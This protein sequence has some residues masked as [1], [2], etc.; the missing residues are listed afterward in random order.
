MKTQAQMLLKDMALEKYN[1]LC[2]HARLLVDYCFTNRVFFNG[3]GECGSPWIE[4]TICDTIEENLEVLLEPY[5][6]G[7]KIG[8]LKE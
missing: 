7:V 5:H 8:E 6:G 3:C 4:C 1:S 2:E